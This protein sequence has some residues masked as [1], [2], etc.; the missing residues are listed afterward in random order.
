MSFANVGD[1]G[2][3]NEQDGGNGDASV[4]VGPTSTAT[5]V[6][7]TGKPSGAGKRGGIG[8]WIAGLVGV[9]VGIA[10]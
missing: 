5:V 4:P 7:T 3:L 9:V 1:C 6:T 8:L 10:I 2:F